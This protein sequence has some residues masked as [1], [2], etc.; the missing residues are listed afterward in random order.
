MP[1][2]WQQSQNFL[3]GD[4]LLDF[5]VIL[6]RCVLG[7]M[8]REK[9]MDK[10]D[11]VFQIWKK[12]INREHLNEIESGRAQLL[13]SFWSYHWATL[14]TESHDE[15]SALIIILLELGV[16]VK[17]W[18]TQ[19]FK[20]L[21]DGILED[22]ST[23][24]PDKKIELGQNEGGD[25]SLRWVWTYQLYGP[26]TQ[27]YTLLSQYETIA[28]TPM[29]SQKW[30]FRELVYTTYDDFYRTGPKW[31]SRFKRRMATKTRKERARF[32]EKQAQSKMPGSWVF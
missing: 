12:F 16:H 8:I 15:G 10:R 18:I 20:T 19:E 9:S 3:F 31:D 4:D 6:I 26:N 11:E 14:T 32:G 22:E 29:W 2:L 24:L 30:P 1:W 23:W 25:L 5:Q 21:K 28:T 27:M 13:R 17:T 7:Y